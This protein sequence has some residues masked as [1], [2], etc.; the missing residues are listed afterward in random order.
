[1][2]K[3]ILTF[4]M[5]IV[6]CFAFLQQSFAAP[7]RNTAASKSAKT[8]TIVMENKFL[9]PPDVQY[10]DA[11]LLLDMNSGRLL[12]GKNI[13][14]RVF[15]ASTTKIMTGILAIELGNLDE[16]VTASPEAIEPIT[17]YDSQMGLR[18]G[19][20]LRLKHLVNAMLIPSAN[21][22]ANVIAVHLAGSIEDFAA[23]MNQKA[24]ELGMNHT[25]FENACGMHDD[26]HYTTA[27]DLS[28]LAQYAMKNETFC[29]IVKTATY[30]IPPTNKFDDSRIL[31]N[32]NLFLSSAFHRN[33]LCTG[34]KTGHTSEAGYCL[35]SSAQKNE[36]YLLSIVLGCPNEDLE[37]KA[38]SYIDSK[39]L[40]DFGFQ[41]YINKKVA[42]PGDIVHSAK[43]YEAKGKTPVNLTVDTPINALISSGNSDRQEIE[44]EF[45]LPEQIP[46]PIAAGSVLGTVTYSYHGTKM[47]TANLISINDV[48]RSIFLHLIHIVTK[49]VLSPFFF[50]PVILLLLILRQNRKRRLRKKRRQERR[51]RYAQQSGRSD[52]LK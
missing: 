49:I 39:S 21:D 31:E 47:G 29:K 36:M 5:V 11:A 26:N 41:N 27:R 44:A 14:K 4:A 8:G 32:T 48:E 33:A 38:Y 3:K 46:A 23:M 25:H 18:V 42:T 37:S 50:I 51:T 7:T 20:S 16:I 43:V 22:A 17:I 12:Y 52:Y 13:D 34:I 28:I 6:L 30:R 35:V 15:P 2:K 45:N 10:S 9:Q 19:E 24:K 1:M 40:Y